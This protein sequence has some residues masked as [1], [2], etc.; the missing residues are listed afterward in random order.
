ML[1]SLLGVSGIYI[2]LMVHH[3]PVI[4][5]ETE[6][7]DYACDCIRLL[8]CSNS[9][10]VVIKFHTAYWYQYLE[11]YGIYT[12]LLVHHVPDIKYYTEWCD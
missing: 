4:K 5:Y 12:V 6:W 10:L 1:I 9:R 2:V 7:Y 8:W 11:Y 3:V